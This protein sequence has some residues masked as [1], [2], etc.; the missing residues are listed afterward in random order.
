MSD[1][2]SRP[3]MD[4]YFGR[5]LNRWI[6]HQLK[7]LHFAYLAHVYATSSEDRPVNGRPEALGLPV[8]K[9]WREVHPIGTPG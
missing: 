4:P 6:L 9:R 7:G 1:R 2:I 3:A 5:V 8:G